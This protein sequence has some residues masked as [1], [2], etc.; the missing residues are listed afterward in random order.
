MFLLPKKIQIFLTQFTRLQLSYL[1]NLISLLFVLIISF[2]KNL[3]VV[4]DSYARVEVCIRSNLQLAGTI[5]GVKGALLIM[6]IRGALYFLN[7]K[8]LVSR[9]ITF[10]Y[11]CYEF[12]T[13]S[14]RSFKSTFG[15]AKAITYTCIELTRCNSVL[16]IRSL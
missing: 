8:D 10:N 7:L 2:H 5:I 9:K 13:S 12:S 3:I 16:Q 4:I 11:R 6:E 14:A 1:N 15:H